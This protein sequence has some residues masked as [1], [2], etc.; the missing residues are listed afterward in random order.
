MPGTHQNF[1]T[2]ALIGCRA[3]KA[4]IEEV[5][6]ELQAELRQTRSTVRSIPGKSRRLSPAR[7]QRIVAAQRKRWAAF[8]KAEIK[9]QVEKPNVFSAG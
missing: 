9:P 6:A 3:A 7:R 8:R 4:R 2:M 5:I 1:L